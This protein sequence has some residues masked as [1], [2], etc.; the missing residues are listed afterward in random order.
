MLKKEIQ[1]YQI[2]KF[3]ELSNSVVAH[4]KKEKSL[5]TEKEL[6]FNLRTTRETNKEHE[7]AILKNCY[8]KAISRDTFFELLEE[9]NLKMYERCG[10][11][12]GVV[13]ENYKF[14]FI[15]LGFTPE[16]FKDLERLN[17]RGRELRENKE[18]KEYKI[19]ER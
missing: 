14:R 3:P 5:L 18:R 15:R 1:N 11:T 8:K 7:I 17:D 19:L 4:G 13:F 9:C 2:K 12:T 16:I 10:K 6:Q